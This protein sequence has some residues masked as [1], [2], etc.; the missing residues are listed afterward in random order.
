[1]FILKTDWLKG[2]INLLVKLSNYNLMNSI[3]LKGGKILRENHTRY[4]KCWIAIL[5]DFEGFR[6]SL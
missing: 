2:F 6:P 4:P 3:Y 5:A 1:M